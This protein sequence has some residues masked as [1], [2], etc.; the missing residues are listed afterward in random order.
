M[1]TITLTYEETYDCDYCTW[2][3]EDTDKIQLKT[4]CEDHWKGSNE[5]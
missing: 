5:S 2:Y 1:T 3:W 4:P